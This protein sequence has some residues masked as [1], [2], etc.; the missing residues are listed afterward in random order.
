MVEA[1]TRWFIGAA[2]EAGTGRQLAVPELPCDLGCG[3]DPADYLDHAVAG[4]SSRSEPPV[5]LAA[6]IHLRFE[7]S[8]I[9]RHGRQSNERLNTVLGPLE[10]R[11]VRELPALALPVGLRW[12][13]TRNYVSTPS[14]IV[15]EPGYPGRHPQGLE[16]HR[17]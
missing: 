14:P 3:A 15:P 7:Q 1:H 11:A 4:S 12:A 8:P 10:W 13:L 2:P 16:G 17:S 5:T 9:H 6:A